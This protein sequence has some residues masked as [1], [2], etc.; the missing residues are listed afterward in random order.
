MS[1]NCV[2]I[3]DEYPAIELLET[4][5]D[6]VPY[7]KTKGTFDNASLAINFL[8]SNT[9]DLAFIDIEMP[10]MS[11]FNLIDHLIQKPYIVLTSA[12]DKYALKAYDLAVND[13]ILKPISFDRFFESVKRAKKQIERNNFYFNNKSHSINIRTG[14]KIERIDIDDI[15]YVQGMSDY[16]SINTKTKRILTLMTFQELMEK[17]PHEKFSR[18]HRSYLV[19]TDKIDQ[20]NSNKIIIGNTDIPIGRTYKNDFFY[21]L[22]K[23]A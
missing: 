18:V 6:R 9:V 22:E 15:L 1:I 7:L 4:Y 19:A 14:W 3:D 11:G 21:K 2:I 5:V 10:N 16:L 23:I 17:L 8:N 12:F 13:Y 20:I